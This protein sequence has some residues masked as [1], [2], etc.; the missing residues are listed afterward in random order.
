MKAKDKR[1]HHYW[2]DFKC[3]G[4][5]DEGELGVDITERSPF[6]CPAGCGATYV[7]WHPP[8]AMA[9]LKCVVKPIFEGG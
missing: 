9:A 4:C 8:G 1:D 5:G 7:Q 2:Y 6:G 3:E